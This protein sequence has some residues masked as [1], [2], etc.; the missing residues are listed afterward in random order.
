MILGAYYP[1]VRNFQ[2]FLPRPPNFLLQSESYELR[3]RSFPP[4]VIFWQKRQ[5]PVDGHN[6]FRSACTVVASGS[7]PN[8]TGSRGSVDDILPAIEI[9]TIHTNPKRKRGNDLPS[10]L[11]PRV[12][13]NLNR[14][15]YTTQPQVRR[16]GET[17]LSHS[18]KLSEFFGD[19]PANSL[20]LPGGP[21]NTGG[22]SVGRLDG[23]A[24]P[25]Q[26]EEQ[27]FVP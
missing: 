14:G 15:Q 13:V 23:I 25:R 9:V 6:S 4:N 1:F 11:T 24:P 17:I 20:D 21:M 12:S 2:E 27:R 10:S 3:S 18:S 5:T 8:G 22:S 16:R 26:P 19:H 7:M